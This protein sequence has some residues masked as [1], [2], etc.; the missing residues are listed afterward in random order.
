M[1]LWL[2]IFILILNVFAHLPTMLGF[3]SLDSNIF[4]FSEH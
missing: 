3:H 1:K 2:T 4:P